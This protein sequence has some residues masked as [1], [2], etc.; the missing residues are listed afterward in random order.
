MITRF[1]TLS[2]ITLISMGMLALSACT[3]I[4][5]AEVKKQSVHQGI[6]ATERLI[7]TLAAASNWEQG[8]RDAYRATRNNK[9]EQAMAGF[10]SIAIESRSAMIAAVPA[11]NAKEIAAL[12]TVH[13]RALSAFAEAVNAD[14]PLL[15][16]RPTTVSVDGKTYHIKG[17]GKS[18]V[19]AKFYDKFIA[20]S[21]LAGR[22]HTIT[23][24]SGIGAPLVA[25]RR[26]TEERENEF[27]FYSKRGLHMDLTLTVDDV[28]DTADG[29]DVFISLRRPI[30]H[31][32][33]SV[34]P[35]SAPMAADFSAAMEVILTGRSELM[36]GLGGF[37][38]ADKRIKQSGIYLLEPYDPERIPV[39]LS[40]GLISV[41]II[42]RDLIPALMAEPDIG[43]KYQFMVFT[44]PSSVPVAYSA[45][46]FRKELKELRKRCDPDRN[47][48]LSSDMIAV[49]HS[50]G[51]VLTHMLVA[52]F[53]DIYW[54][55]I[56]DIPI[57]EL[58]IDPEARKKILSLAYFDPDEGITRVVYMSAPHLGADMAKAS[59]SALASTLVTLP[60]SLVQQTAAILTPALKEHLKLNI[61]KKITAI[62]SLRPD[63]PTALALGKAPYKEGVIYHSIIGDRG[64]GDTPKSSDGIVEYWSSHQEGA[65]SE[66]IVPTGHGSYKSPLATDEMKRILRQH[67]NLRQPKSE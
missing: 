31:G 19:A 8:F 20:V 10:M 44:Y 5:V 34:G 61:G 43:E 45:R 39:I 52:D 15:K 65:A 23:N 41:P 56:S 42:W 66:L 3:T 28:R 67:A 1:A 37:F 7:A 2:R 12:A 27:R 51:G 13:N 29:T 49:G 11:G 35:Y 22:N 59:F 54:N 4:D 46:L 53:G 38:Q 47:D 62:Q 6:D 17:S 24:R 60:A 18:D 36:W 50:M 30:M 57:D 16:G 9:H 25:V 33:T 21:S 64:K 63:S 26:Y 14:S 55:E 40:H 48:A 32:L 58:K